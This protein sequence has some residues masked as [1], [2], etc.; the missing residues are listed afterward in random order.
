MKNAYTKKPIDLLIE[1]ETYCKELQ[2]LHS[3]HYY[4]MLNVYGICKPASLICENDYTA[5]LKE[6]VTVFIQAV[7]LAINYWHNNKTLLVTAYA[8]IEQAKNEPDK[9]TR[10]LLRKNA[11]AAFSIASRPRPWRYLAFLTCL[12]LVQ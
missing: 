8:F 10:I 2:T 3:D 7:T 6:A 4:R 5:P 11:G 12:K 1:F 9:A